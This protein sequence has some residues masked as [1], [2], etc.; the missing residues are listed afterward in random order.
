MRHAFAVHLLESEPTCAPSNFCSAIAAWPPPHDTCASPPLKCAR[1]PVHWTCYR[2]PCR[3]RPHPLHLSTSEHRGRSEAG[4]G[5]CVPPLRRSLPTTTWR[6]DVSSAA[7]RH[8]GYRGVPYRGSRR[9][10]RTL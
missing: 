1:P 3:W 9:P 6:V 5:G 2:V 7:A 8:D 4:S 10:P